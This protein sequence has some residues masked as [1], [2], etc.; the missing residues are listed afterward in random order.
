M[1]KHNLYEIYT[2]EHDIQRKRCQ[3]LAKKHSELFPGAENLRFFSAPGRIEIC[4]NHTDHN[5]GKVLAAAIDQD[6]LCAASKSYDNTVTLY[7]AGY[8]KPFSIDVTDLA[9]RGDERNT[10]SALLRGVCAVMKA[11][12]TALCGFNAVMDSNVMVGSG[13]SSS[14]AIEVLIATVVDGLFGSG[15]AEPIAKAQAAQYAENVYF[16]KPSGLMDQAASSLGGL[17]KIDFGRGEPIIEKLDAGFDQSGYA[18]AVV[19][20]GASHENLTSCYARIPG[21]M[22]AVSNFFGKEYL[23]EISETQFHQALPRLHA[24]LCEGQILRALHY[25]AENR[26]VDK[27]S[28]ALEHGCFHIALDTIIKSGQSSWMYLQNVLAPGERQPLALA[29]AVSES[30]LGGSGAWRVHGGGFA[31]TILAVMPKEALGGYV[32]GMDAIFGEG[33]A[34]PLAIRNPGA[35]EVIL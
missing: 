32:I 19:N 17:V 29:L 28:A 23:R 30:L 21:D 5:H 4:G 15:E 33:A 10:T 11:R 6:A 27:L 1:S 14:A 31:G 7:S 34:V 35:C 9:P 3:E 26:R 24:N 20:S 8:E 16:G 12:G 2:G 13:L 22:K 18:V 25:F